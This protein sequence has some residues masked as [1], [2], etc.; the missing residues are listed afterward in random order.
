MYRRDKCTG[1]GRCAGHENDYDFLCYHGAKEWCG[2]EV[3]SDEVFDE[4][5]KDAVFYKNS[6]G[7]L[8]LSGGEPLSQFDFARDILVM[9]KQNGIHTAIETCGSTTSKRMREIAEFTDLFLFDYKETDSELH[10]QFTGVDNTVILENL[11]LLDSLG[12]D[13]VLRCPVIKGCN[14]R[15][16]HF[17]GICETANK[18]KNIKMIEILPYHSLGESKYAALG[19]ENSSFELLSDEE[20]AEV[21][22][23]IRSGTR[24]NVRKA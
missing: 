1:C 10:R 18:L 7:G 20:I 5:M 2:R 24:V 12:K 8:T 16:E 3:S 15:S 6:G 9:A 4:V 17:R 11:N 13:I 22:D 21:I 23:I 19:M 14:F